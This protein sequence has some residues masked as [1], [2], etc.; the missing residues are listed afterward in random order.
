MKKFV[1]GLVAAAAV[2]API[3]LSAGS[4]NAATTDAKGV[5]TVTKGDIQSA[6]G[7]NN[8][9]WDAAIG[10]TNG[11]AKVGSLVTATTNSIQPV[12]SGMGWWTLNGQIVAD[13]PNDE[14]INPN[15]TDPDKWC[16][17]NYPIDTTYTGGVSTTITPIINAQQKVTG[18]KV[19]AASTDGYVYWTRHTTFGCTGSDNTWEYNVTMRWPTSV[20]GGGISGVT[21][22]GKPVAVTPYVAPAA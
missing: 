18:Y 9:A 11:P 12:P 21:V 4:A 22:N 15:V 13:Y 17:A 19:A 16:V 2:A 14:Y 8:A 5:V 10:A 1:L 6:M 7:W 20:A 3:A